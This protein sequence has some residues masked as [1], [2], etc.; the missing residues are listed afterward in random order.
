MTEYGVKFL[1]LYS[2]CL[3]IIYYSSVYMSILNS[4]FIP[5]AFP[6]GNCKCVSKSVSL[7]YK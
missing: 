5:L 7:F 4:E 2:K 6:L 1:V 3:L